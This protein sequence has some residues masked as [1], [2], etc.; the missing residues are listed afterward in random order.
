MICRIS[1]LPPLE[2]DER[3]SLGKRIDDDWHH[4]L[5]IDADLI[6]AFKI[7]KSKR[8]SETRLDICKFTYI[9]L[10][11]KNI[12]EIH[13]KDRNFLNALIIYYFNY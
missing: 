3:S 6:N 4:K 2:T 5:Y 8:L 9:L 12:R 13:L 11:C 7:D 10:K 1:P